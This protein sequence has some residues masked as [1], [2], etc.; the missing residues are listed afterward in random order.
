MARKIKTFVLVCAFSIWGTLPA[1]AG[2]NFGSK[3][4]IQIPNTEDLIKHCWDISEEKRST[5]NTAMM[6]EGHLDTALCLEQEIIT[7]AAALIEETSMT[8]KQIV[9]LINNLH[10]AYGRLYW[11]MYNE[12]K[13][14]GFS[15]GTIHHPRH[16]TQ[17][18]LLYEKILWDIID[19][20]KEYGV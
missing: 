12:N 11:M 5:P 3:A 4:S 10:D 13:G 9:S 14:C 17:V 8:R 20:R 16:N 7:H 15:C 1:I 2:G 19:L 18:A 6:R